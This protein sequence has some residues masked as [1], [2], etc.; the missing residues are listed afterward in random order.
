MKIIIP[1]EAIL[2]DAEEIRAIT[3]RA[4]RDQQVEWF[5]KNGWKFVKNAANQPVVG[6]LYAT[7]KL[8]GREL[9]DLPV[10]AGLPD[11]SK[12]D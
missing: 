11:F 6:R 3:G 9:G 5:S 1:A 12:M 2:L 7:I 4:R 10:S 8:A